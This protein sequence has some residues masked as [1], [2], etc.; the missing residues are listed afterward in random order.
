MTVVIKP[1]WLF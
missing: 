1:V